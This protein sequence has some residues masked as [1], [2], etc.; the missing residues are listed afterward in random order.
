MNHLRPAVA[1][2]NVAFQLYPCPRPMAENTRRRVM[3]PSR[4][5]LEKNLPKHSYPKGE[6]LL[7]PSPKQERVGG[8]T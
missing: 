6:I 1:Q 4:G 3:S 2:S 5:S 7:I 8:G